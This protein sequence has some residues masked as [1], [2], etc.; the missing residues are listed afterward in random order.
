MITAGIS[1]KT[2]ALYMAKIF[3][4]TKQERLKKSWAAVKRMHSDSIADTVIADEL[5][6]C[7]NCLKAGYLLD[8]GGI[9]LKC[10]NCGQEWIVFDNKGW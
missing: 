3:K 9:L 10:L 7:P 6:I 1:E 2:F 8:N 5:G 4:G